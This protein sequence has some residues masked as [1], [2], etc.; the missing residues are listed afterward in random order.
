MGESIPKGV[1]MERRGAPM[2][3][4]KERYFSPEVHRRLPLIQRGSRSR[5]LA[6]LT[7]STMEVRIEHMHKVLDRYLG[8]EG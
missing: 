5:G 6:E 1:V 2:R 3:I 8:G 7:L 4:S